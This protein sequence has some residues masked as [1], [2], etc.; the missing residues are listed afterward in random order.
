MKFKWNIADEHRWDRYKKEQGEE[1]SD[2]GNYIGSVR[3]GDLC[4]DI[5]EWGNHLWFDL[6][7]GGVDTG[8]GYGADGYPYDFFDVLGFAWYDKIRDTTDAEFKEQVEK[9]ITEILKK[10]PEYTTDT[11]NIKVNLIEKANMEMQEW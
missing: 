10:N 11:R 6:Y 1:E 8:Y 3:A 7:V 5:L 2:S 4:F 9:H